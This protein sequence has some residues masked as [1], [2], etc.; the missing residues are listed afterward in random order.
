MI[1][2]RLTRPTVG[3]IPTRPF[4]VPGLRM[5]PEVSVPMPTAAR[6]AETAM[7][8][9]EL[10][11]PGVSVGRPSLTGRLKVSRI[12]RGSGRGSY[13]LNPYPPRELYPDGIPLVRK[14]ANSVIVALPRMMAPAAR[15]RRATNASDLGNDPLNA[16][17]PAVVGM[18]RVSILSLR[19]IGMPGAAGHCR[20]GRCP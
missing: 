2:S 8:G 17:E 20:L 9:P 14:L 13:G 10:E 5:E 11:P 16:T 18:S 12:A 6:F 15:R 1:P 4:A 7:P 19:I 3:L